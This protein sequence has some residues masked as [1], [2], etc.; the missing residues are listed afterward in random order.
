MEDGI[1]KA[2]KEMNDYRDKESRYGKLEDGG[3]SLELLREEECHSDV[4]IEKERGLDL[5]QWHL[6]YDTN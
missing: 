6:W 1:G 3:N 4:A 5:M 2:V